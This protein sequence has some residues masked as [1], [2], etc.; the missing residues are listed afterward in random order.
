MKRH[1]I[2][3]GLVR[4]LRLTWSINSLIESRLRWKDVVADFF[5]DKKQEYYFKCK[6]MG[7]IEEHYIIGSHIVPPLAATVI[8]FAKTSSR[9]IKTR[10]S[11]I[12]KRK[13]CCRF[14]YFRGLGSSKLSGAWTTDLPRQIMHLYKLTDM[15]YPTLEV[16]R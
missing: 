11:H 14:S 5:Y 1:L 12:Q 10:F 6:H 13:A 15:D 9:S 2:Y 3:I 4:P 16:Y 8:P 7:H